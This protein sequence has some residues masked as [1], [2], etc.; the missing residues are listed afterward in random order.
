MWQPLS[1]MSETDILQEARRSNIRISGLEDMEDSWIP[2][3][4]VITYSENMITLH[5]TY[6]GHLHDAL[7]GAIMHENNGLKS[8][9][10][11]KSL[12]TRPDSVLEHIESYG[13]D[14]GLHLA[15]LYPKLEPVSSISNIGD[16][17]ECFIGCV[18]GEFT[19][20]LYQA[21]FLGAGLA[22]DCVW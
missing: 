5:E 9:K 15:V 22:I 20:R 13:E 4:E 18:D 11:A 6:R 12:R 14:L 2:F 19:S 10:L 17:L 8:N 21:S 16:F 1:R 7:H 3:P